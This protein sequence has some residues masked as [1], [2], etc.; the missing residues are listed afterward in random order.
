MAL[1]LAVLA[2]APKCGT[3]ALARGLAVHPKVV[4]SDPKEPYYFGSELGPLRRRDGITSPERYAGCFVLGDR[5]RATI[6]C[7]GTTLYLSSPDALSQLV[8][9]HPEVKVVCILR[10]PVELAHAFH[11][12]MVYSEFEDIDDFGE[13]WR[14]QDA[15]RVAP[16]ARCPVPRLLQYRELASVGTQLVYAR[17]TISPGQLHVVLYDDLV[18]DPRKTLRGIGLFLGIEADSLAIPPGENSAMHLRSRWVA[19]AVRTPRGRRLARWTRAYLPARPVRALKVA[20]TRLL[21]SDVTRESIEADLRAELTTVFA[22]EISQIEEILERPL[23]PWRK[24]TR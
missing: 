14:A 20:K 19:R 16:P 6:R 10:N 17:K 18:Q 4:F 23:D 9:A 8:T 13:A 7:E 22:P 2:G 21:R 11:M 5:K 3:T 1:P 12:Q 24:L 15:R